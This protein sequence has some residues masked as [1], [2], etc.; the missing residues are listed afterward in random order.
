MKKIILELVNED[1][2]P[3]ITNS[4]LDLAANALYRLVNKNSSF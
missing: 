1:E 2:T 4:N 3:F